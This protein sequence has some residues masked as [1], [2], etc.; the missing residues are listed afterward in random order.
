MSKLLLV[1]I[2]KRALSF[3]Q[4]QM[5]RAWWLKVLQVEIT[6]AG[7]G[8]ERLSGKLFG[9]YNICF[10]H[11][12]TAK[13][14]GCQLR[15]GT[16]RNL[17]ICLTLAS[18]SVRF[19]RNHLE[20]LGPMW[21]PHHQE[22]LRLESGSDRLAMIPSQEHHHKLFKPWKIPDTKRHTEVVYPTLCT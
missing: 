14:W 4:L 8:M 12:E 15:L 20:F 7:P 18:I 11:V 19:P 22:Y 3:C 17:I 10:H 6:C 13:Y 16:S 2:Y 9:N 21:L 5:R 1:Q